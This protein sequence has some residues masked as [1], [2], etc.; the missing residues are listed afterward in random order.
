MK[1]IL[2]LVLSLVLLTSGLCACKAS[3]S[4]LYGAWYRDVNG[5]RDAIQLSVNDDGKEVFIWAI[6][7]IENDSVTSVSKGY[8]HISGNTITLD[9]LTSDVDLTLTY[10]LEGDK[11]TLSSDTASIVLTKFV[12]DE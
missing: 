1:R 7:D 8:F 9:Y 6:Y 10:I 4:E 2:S 11:L 12:L 3:H 5:Q